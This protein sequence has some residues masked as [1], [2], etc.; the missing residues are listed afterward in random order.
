MD[1]KLEYIR[2]FKHSQVARADYKQM[3]DSVGIFVAIEQGSSAQELASESFA[4]KDEEAY[5]KRYIEVMYNSLKKVEETGNSDFV[6]HWIRAFPP[7]KY[8]VD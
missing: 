2:T 5:K 7:L 4:P 6:T 1:E 8:P 3:F